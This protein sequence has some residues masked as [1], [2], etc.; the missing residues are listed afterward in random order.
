MTVFG[1]GAFGRESALDE[2]MRVEPH[3]WDRC[4]V[5]RD[6][7]ELTCVFSRSSLPSPGPLLLSLSLL[8]A[9]KE[10]ATGAHNEMEISHKARTE[11]AE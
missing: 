9:H 10:E 4:P 2:A 1:D 6:T 7:R 3:E 8:H 11:A 5:R